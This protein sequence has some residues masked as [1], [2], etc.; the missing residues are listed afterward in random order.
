M[1][2]QTD[3]SITSSSYPNDAFQLESPCMESILEGI[4]FWAK[5]TPDSVSIRYP[6]GPDTTSFESVTWKEYKVTGIIDLQSIF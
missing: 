1:T 5:N 4:K 2:A 3:K 6:P